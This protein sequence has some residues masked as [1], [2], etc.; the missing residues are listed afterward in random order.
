M[1][2]DSF[3][4]GDRGRTVLGETFRSLGDRA[5]E[6]LRRQV[7]EGE[8]APGRRLVEREVAATLGVSRITVR[9]AFH[10]LEAEGLLTRMARRG[11][12]V[13]PMTKSDV[14]DLFEVRESV[15]VLA[16]RLAAERRSRAD[17]RVLEDLMDQAADGTTRSDDALVARANVEFHVR[18]V[19]A[20]N[21]DLLVSLMAP[22]HSRVHRLFV[23]SRSVLDLNQMWTE[24]HALY[25]AIASGDSDRAGRLA[26]AHIAES[27]TPTLAML[28]HG[29]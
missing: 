12:M 22:L 13:T 4:S 21:N 10:A 15:E 16:A 24:H 8:L 7:V 19:Q 18:I 25:D 28:G 11:V 29:S 2:H 26:L 17:L 5:Y 20:S 6:E 1:A 14:R 9:E 27:R 3:E 23:A